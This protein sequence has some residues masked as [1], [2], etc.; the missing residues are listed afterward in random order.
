[1]EET[2]LVGADGEPIEAPAEE[3]EEPAEDEAASGEAEESE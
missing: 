1:V 2:A 3:G